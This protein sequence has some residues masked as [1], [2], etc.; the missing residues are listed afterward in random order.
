MHHHTVATPTENSDQPDVDRNP[1]GSNPSLEKI[2]AISPS[3]GMKTMRQISVTIV[4]DSTDDAK[5]VPLNME[6]RRPGL[7][8]ASA[9]PSP[10]TTSVG[11][12]NT[13]KTAVLR[14]A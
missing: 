5:N 10:I 2:I 11:T 4:T 7:L 9:S 1:I 14:N 6:D 12:E 8:S 13:T 3:F